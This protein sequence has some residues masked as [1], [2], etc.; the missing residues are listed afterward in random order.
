VAVRPSTSTIRRSIRTQAG[1]CSSYRARASRPSLHSQKLSARS[2]ITFLI[3]SR[4]A[5]SSSTIRTVTMCSAVPIPATG[6]QDAALRRERARVL[7][8]NSNEYMYSFLEFLCFRR[9]ILVNWATELWNRP[10]ACQCIR[11]VVSPKES[12]ASVSSW[13]HTF[14]HVAAL[15]LAATPYGNS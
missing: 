3:S 15:R 8:L 2:P 7:V 5:P 1:R 6:F 13:C 10:L 9:R 11:N 12:T 14:P 4:I